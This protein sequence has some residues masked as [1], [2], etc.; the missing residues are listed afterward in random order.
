MNAIHNHYD[1]IFLI[2][3]HSPETISLKLRNS[4][5]YLLRF[6][7][8]IKFYFCAVMRTLNKKTF[9]EFFAG[10]GLVRSGLELAGWE[11][12]FANDIDPVKRKLYLNHF[13]D[14]ANHF[15]LDDIHNLDAE[16]IPTVDLATASF[17]CTDLSLAGKMAG[18]NG[19]QSSAFWGFMKII[20]D[21]GIRKPRLIL[22][23]NVVAFLTSHKGQDFYNALKAINQEGYVV[24]AFIVNAVHFVPQSRARIFIFGKLTDKVRIPEIKYVSE[25]EIRPKRLVEFIYKHQDLNWSIRNDLPSLPPKQDRLSNIVESIPKTS[26]LWYRKDRVEYL[27]NQTFERHLT[28][29]KELMHEDTYSYLT[30]FRRVRNGKSMAEIRFDGISGCLRTP[31]GGSAKQI[32]LEVGKGQINVRLLTPTEYARLMGADDYKLSG[33]INEAYFG[34]GDAVCVPVITWIAENYLNLEISSMK[35]ATKAIIQY[36]TA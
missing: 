23:E 24:D 19:K 15:L 8:Q 26:S 5:S 17:P 18:L 20:N 1:D 27:L 30:A 2:E 7:M 34:F 13:S 33:T 32:L 11:V 10:I 35:N 14:S 31:K 4:K 25:S 22:L 16:Q 21:M 36:A 9:A 29:I 12:S 28:K 3:N 6:K